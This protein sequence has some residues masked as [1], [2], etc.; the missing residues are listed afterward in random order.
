MYRYTPKIYIFIADLFL[1]VLG[2]LAV[3]MLYIP[4]LNDCYIKRDLCKQDYVTLPVKHIP[5]ECMK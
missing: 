5:V 4:R 2:L 1:L 3:N